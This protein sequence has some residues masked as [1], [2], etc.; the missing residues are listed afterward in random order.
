MSD[1]FIQT[2]TTTTDKGGES[3]VVGDFNNKR[4][5]DISM[6][7]RERRNLKSHVV[8]TVLLAYDGGTHGSLKMD[9]LLQMYNVTLP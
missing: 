7:N 4:D 6:E 5:L 2:E 1:S 3:I 8:E 9:L